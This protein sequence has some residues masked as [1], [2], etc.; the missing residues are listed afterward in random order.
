MSNKFQRGLTFSR[1]EVPLFP[2][3]GGVQMLI[4]IEIHRTCDFPEWVRTAY[5]PSGSAHE[6]TFFYV[7]Y[8]IARFGKAV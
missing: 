7:V 2:G 3:V 5:P 4:S 6:H 1:G 8:H